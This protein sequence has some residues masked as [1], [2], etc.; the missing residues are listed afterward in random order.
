MAL[1]ASAGFQPSIST[2]FDEQLPSQHGE[3]CPSVS[4]GPSLFA[5]CSWSNLKRSGRASICQQPPWES[6]QSLGI[7]GHD[8]GYGIAPIIGIN[9]VDRDNEWVLRDPNPRPQP[10]ESVR[11][12][13]SSP[14]DIKECPA[15]TQN[16]ATGSPRLAP[17]F[18]VA[19]H[20]AR[21]TD[22]PRSTSSISQ[23]RQGAPE[24]N[25]NKSAA[26]AS[27]V[28]VGANQIAAMP[29]GASVALHVDTLVPDL[30]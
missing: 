17:L 16:R 29:T 18:R 20:A 26:I 23:A 21:E 12:T 30:R 8:S 15:Q 1:A 24:A 25:P 11:A 6:H 4:H 22:R 27:R 28:E 13:F 2:R 14:G 9:A 7:S 5:C 3:L 10:C 19:S